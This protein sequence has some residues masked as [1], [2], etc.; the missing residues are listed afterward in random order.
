MTVE[1][2][3]ADEYRKNCIVE[4]ACFDNPS[5]ACT[6]SIPEAQADVCDPRFTF[7]FYE[8]EVWKNFVIGLSIMI[9]W[10][11]VAYVV[12]TL[13]FRERPANFGYDRELIEQYCGKSDVRE[14]LSIDREPLN[15]ELQSF[16][17]K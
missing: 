10:Y 16:S 4:A 2:S 15:A 12:F 8:K 7:D 9:G 3:N 5:K 13:R 6:F 17:N 14:T 1:F 11:I